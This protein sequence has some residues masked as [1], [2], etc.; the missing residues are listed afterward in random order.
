LGFQVSDCYGESTS[1]QA[2]IAATTAQNS[3]GY[4][5]QGDGIDAT[6]AQNCS[7]FSRTNGTGIS[8]NNAENCYGSAMSGT[9]ISAQTVGNCYGSSYAGTGI[10]ATTAAN[11]YSFGACGLQVTGGGSASG[12]ATYFSSNGIV[13]GVSCIL[14][15]CVTY[16]C[17]GTGITAGQGCLVQGCTMQSSGANGVVADTGSTITECNVQASGNIGIMAT[18][19]I[20][21]GCTVLTNGFYGIYNVSGTVSGCTVK[22][23][24]YSGIFADGSGGGKITGNNCSGNNTSWSLYHAGI[25]LYGSNNRVEDNH[26]NGSGTAGIHVRDF[27]LVP[28]AP[29]ATNNVMVK[30]TV[31]GDGANNFMYPINND[32]GPI[33]TAATATSPFANISH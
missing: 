4:S 11:C 20:V 30:N 27:A 21:A 23:T 29:P 19:S 12:C 25:M 16:H 6:T 14:K 7:G 3:Y 32:V 1:A 26:V 15:N 13:A 28:P 5:A 10:Y 24:L 9:G 22:G 17:T 8:A 33:G 31:A 18:N 2:G